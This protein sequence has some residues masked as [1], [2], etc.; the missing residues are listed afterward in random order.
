[1]KIMKIENLFDDDDCQSGGYKKHPYGRMK[2][3][4]EGF[5]LITI[6]P[7]CKKIH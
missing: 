1:M 6:G 7:N 2:V 5:I 4:Y 3:L